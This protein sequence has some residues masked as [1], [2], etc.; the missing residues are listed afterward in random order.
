MGVSGVAEW[1]N[2]DCVETMTMANS[3]KCPPFTDSDGINFIS[4]TEQARPEVW[5]VPL[6]LMLISAKQPERL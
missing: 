3:S 2:L 5:M 6:V 4:F 1:W